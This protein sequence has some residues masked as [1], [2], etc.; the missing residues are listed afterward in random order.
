MKGKERKPL[1]EPWGICIENKA[2]NGENLLGR[3]AEAVIIR[4][5][6]HGIWWKIRFNEE[7]NTVLQCG[8][9][10]GGW[11]QYWFH[12]VSKKL[13]HILSRTLFIVKDNFFKG[14]NEQGSF[15]EQL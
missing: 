8:K 10:Q 3:N 13:L 4:S 11:R 14:W 1:A 12:C 9:G 2:E 7:V 6:Y 15:K 5:G